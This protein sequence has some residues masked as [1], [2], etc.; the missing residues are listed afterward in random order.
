MEK[1][2]D[3][4]V[5]RKDS[6][7]YRNECKECLS[8][9]S[10]IRRMSYKNNHSEVEEQICGSCNILKSADCFYKNDHTKSGLAG[11]CKICSDSDKKIY[12]ENNKEKIFNRGVN[13]RKNNKEDI[14]NQKSIYYQN[15][16]LSIFEK[17]NIYYKNKRNTDPLF[18]LKINISRKIHFALDGRKNG[19]SILK[20]LQYSM[21]DLKEHFES[22][23]EPWMNWSNQGKY[24]KNIWDDNDQTTWVW[25]LDHIIP[26]SEFNYTSMDDR[27]FRDC[28]ALSNLRPYSAKQNILDGAQRTR[29]SKVVKGIL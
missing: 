4:F 28:W 14:T 18:K 5:F 15:N 17:Q 3:C 19:E 25:N 23:F 27:S 8:V 2:L 21:Q 7:K 12:I 6:N 16:K 24:Y 20:Y 10:K 1:D 22:L 13:Y 11:Y 29:H 26:Q 9:A